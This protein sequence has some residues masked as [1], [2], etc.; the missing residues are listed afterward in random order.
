MKADR[1][2]GAVPRDRGVRAGVDLGNGPSEGESLEVL[3]VEDTPEDLRLLT[4]LVSAKGYRVYAYPDA[5]GGWKHFLEHRPAVAIVD[6]ILPGMDGL[7]LCRRIRGVAGGEECVVLVVTVRVSPE[8]LEEALRAG[9]DDFVP[10]PLD[11]TLFQVRLAV[12]ARTARTRRE[13]MQALRELE[14]RTR[15]SSLLFRISEI[16]LR[17]G[18]FRELLEAVLDEIQRVTGVQ[19]LMVEEFQSGTAHLRPLVFRG[20]DPP[21]PPSFPLGESPASQAVE[22]GKMVLKRNFPGSRWLGPHPP[23]LRGLEWLLF[24]PLISEG[25]TLGVMTLGGREG[26]PPP[27]DLPSW[28]EG[29]GQALASFLARREAEEALRQGQEEALALAFELEKANRELEAFAYSVSHDLQAPLKTIQG[30]A[31]SLQRDFA[32]RLPVEAQDYVRR[33]LEGGRK[34]ELLIRDLLAYS[35]VS[36]GEVALVEVGVRQVVKEAIEQVAGH[37][38]ESEAAVEVQ[39]GDETV[40][41]QPTLLGQALANLLSNAAKFTRPG[42]PPRIR[43]SWERR[44]PYLH[45]EVE[46][47]G[48]GIPKEQ[49]ERIFRM[50]ERLPSSRSRP[51]T[52]VG[53]ALVRRA[54]ERM[55]G[56]VGVESEPGK[57]SRFW[58]EL[59]VPVP[60][61]ADQRLRRKR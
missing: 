22:T 24:V 7:E 36:S 51:G 13:R 29:V 6:W 28:G 61:E 34:M 19:V 38:V 47:N 23:H 48:T 10:K 17:S 46:D 41:A 8:D 25:V 54:V 43:V 20:L 60:P 59:A 55:G 52:G 44:G 18:D 16:T 50:F 2:E 11:P 33:I 49:Q 5:E 58:L 42:V 1:K 14:R 45:L 15:E 4:G 35:R 32:D 27:A 31:H 12:A 40:L 39:G 56:R 26:T 3:L 30:F 53:L 37:L 57:G 21:P 9:A